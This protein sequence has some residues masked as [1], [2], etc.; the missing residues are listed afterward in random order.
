LTSSTHKFESKTLELFV[1]RLRE[2]M[3]VKFGQTPDM[4]DV[5]Q[6]FREVADTASQVWYW[7]SA[8]MLGTDPHASDWRLVLDRLRGLETIKQ[9]TRD[10]VRLL[11]RDRSMRHFSAEAFGT[12]KTALRAG[13]LANAVYATG[14]LLEFFW[15][16]IGLETGPWPEIARTLDG[17]FRVQTGN[18]IVRRSRWTR[19]A[20]AVWERHL[21]FAPI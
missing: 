20:H 19:N 9:R 3:A 10:W 2:A 6:R 11:V 17:L 18:G 16:E 1:T 14:C 12:L 4:A 7:E 15:D 13:S 5:E 8:H 21:R